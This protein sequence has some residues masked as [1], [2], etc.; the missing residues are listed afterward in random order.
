ME[1]RTNAPE[2]KIPFRLPLRVY[3]SY[4]LVITLI[5]TAVSFAKFATSGAGGDSAR[6]A[7]FAVSAAGESDTALAMSFDSVTGTKQDSYTITVYNYDASTTAEV[8][9][10]YDVVVTVDGT[11]PAGVS[12]TVDGKNASSVNGSVYTFSGVGELAGGSRNTASHTLTFTGDSSK[13]VSDFTG[14]NSLEFSIS[15]NFEQID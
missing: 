13:I 5:F 4:L 2:N 8:A 9:V 14:E 7:S 15:V 12:F 10:R 1:R 3:L 11:L 6:V